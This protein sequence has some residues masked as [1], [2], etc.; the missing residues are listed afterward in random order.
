MIS[1]NEKFLKHVSLGKF[2][3]MKRDL[4]KGANINVRDNQG[5]NAL[6]IAIDETPSFETAILIASSLTDLTDNYGMKIDL[7]AKDNSGATALDRNEFF[8][9][10]L[11]LEKDYREIRDLL[12]KK[13]VEAGVDFSLSDLQ[14]G[15][16][17][18]KE[19]DAFIKKL[20]ANRLGKIL[21]DLYFDPMRFL[22]LPTE[23]FVIKGDVDAMQRMAKKGYDNL[24]SLIQ[25]KKEIAEQKRRSDIIIDEFISDPIYKKQ[26]K[27]ED[28]YTSVAIRQR[29]AR[30]MFEKQILEKR[31]DE[32]QKIKDFET[33][34]KMPY[35]RR[36]FQYVSQKYPKQEDWTLYDDIIIYDD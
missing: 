2:K 24:T 8:T 7:H 36:N 4:L 13:L 6:M 22:S 34:Y 29:T 11:D 30:D 19:D 25:I 18:K 35:S 3:K 31:R 20:Q 28:F 5:R 10:C 17:V 21:V 27:K 32:E 26:L 16:L 14:D 1:L 23:C 15:E 9:E 12:F 33:T